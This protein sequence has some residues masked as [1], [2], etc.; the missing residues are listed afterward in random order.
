ML[1]VLLNLFRLVFGDKI[2]R[3][4]GW[5]TD[6][7][8]RMRIASA[9]VCAYKSH[10]LAYSATVM[11]T[12]GEERY[13]IWVDN[14]PHA[15]A[16]DGHIHLREGRNGICG[17]RGV[18]MIWFQNTSPRFSLRMKL[19]NLF[20][21]HLLYYCCFTCTSEQLVFTPRIVESIC[22]ESRQ[23]ASRD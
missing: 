2:P 14:S 20:I 13:G 22:F 5:R 17:T 6:A 10:T 4:D 23:A 16:S 18:E 1:Q 8:W 19:C 3:C 15:T 7:N 12:F 21:L 9:T 11:S